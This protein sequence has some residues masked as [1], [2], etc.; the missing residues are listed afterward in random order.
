MIKQKPILYSTAIILLV[1]SG[2]SINKTEVSP[3]Q[4]ST[5]NTMS[6]SVTATS[7]G[8]VMQH[9]LDKWLKEEWSPMMTPA[10]PI[11]QTKTQSDMNLSTPSTTA[12]IVANPMDEK[13]FTL[14][15]Y[16]DKWKVYHENKSKMEEAQPKE[17]S[18]VEKMQRM[19]AIGK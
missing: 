13:P 11:V 18:H 3:S 7:E 14:Q 12:T 8:G 6:P 19:P 9:S 1:I 15:K 10:E 5:L 2:C 16:V 4:N 17:P